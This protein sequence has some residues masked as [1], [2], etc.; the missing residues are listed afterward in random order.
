MG[1]M[2]Q[3]RAG[4]V[5]TDVDA[6]ADLVEALR[7]D[8][9]TA[10]ERLVAAHGERAYRLAIRITRHAPDAEEVVQDALWAVVRKIESFRGTSAFRSW[11]Y[12]IVANAA[13][14]KVR[15]R[16]GRRVERPL[17]EVAPLIEESDRPGGDWPGGLGDPSLQTE[18][19]IVLG[20]AIAALPEGYR[21]A[22]LL[23]DVADFSAREIA[24]ALGITRANVKSRLHRARV[25][26]RRR[27]EGH[28]VVGRPRPRRGRT[29]GRRRELA[30]CAA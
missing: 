3:R 2:V 29:S 23:H 15:G 20:S 14:Q 27:L 12:R 26:L 19:R 17:E 28:V 6:D 5:D 18:L 13:L 24:G 25:V 10:A 30:T 8:E 9:T 4:T 21:I 22:V 7:R 1:R 16:R 11:L